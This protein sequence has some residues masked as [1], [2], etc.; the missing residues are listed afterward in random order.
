MSIASVRGGLVCIIIPFFLETS[1]SEKGGEYR[2]KVFDGV[3]V[4]IKSGF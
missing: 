2:F 3:A 1:A 4:E